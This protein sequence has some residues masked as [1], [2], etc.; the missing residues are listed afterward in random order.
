[1]WNHAPTMEKLVQEKG[2]QWPKFEGDEMRDL[3]EYIRSFARESAQR[4][5]GR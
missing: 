1:M 3:V 4:R 5:T 2:L